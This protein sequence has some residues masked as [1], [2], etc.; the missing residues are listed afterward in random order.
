MPFLSPADSHFDLGKLPFHEAIEEIKINRELLEEI[1]GKP[2]EHLF[3]SFRTCRTFSAEL[4]PCCL[5]K[6]FK[7]ELVR[8]RKG[9]ALVLIR[10]I[11]IVLDGD[12]IYQ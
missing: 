2:I 4:Q 1:I 8:F 9:S 7:T 11:F 5:A 6:D 12:L 10:L 3:F